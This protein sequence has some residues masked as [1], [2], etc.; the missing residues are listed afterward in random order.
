M[1]RLTKQTT[2]SGLG[3]HS[4]RNSPRILLQ[5][6]RP[7][8]TMMP[9]TLVDLLLPV[10]GAACSATNNCFYVLLLLIVDGGQLLA[11]RLQLTTPGT[12]S[13]WGSSSRPWLPLKIRKG[14][15]VSQIENDLLYKTRPDKLSPL[16]SLTVSKS[17][18]KFVRQA[19]RH[20]LLAL[21]F[22]DR[23]LPLPPPGL[24]PTTPVLDVPHSAC[25]SPRSC[26]RC[27]TRVGVDLQL[28]HGPHVVQ[29]A[30]HAQPQRRCLSYP[31]EL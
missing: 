16:R 4:P 8:R 15:A 1:H 13:S 23:K 3:L 30:L 10:V 9:N 17:R 5:R 22:H 31:V 11:M 24:V 21:H 6:I 28:R 29:E 18:T 25:T 7:S 19:I 2:I 12:I 20:V 27:L 26:A 14:E